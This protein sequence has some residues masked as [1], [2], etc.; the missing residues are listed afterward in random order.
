[1]IISYLGLKFTNL[2]NTLNQSWTKA[3]ALPP[4]RPVRD[5]NDFTNLAELSVFQFPIHEYHGYEDLILYLVNARDGDSEKVLELAGK[6]DSLCTLLRASR[7]SGLENKWAV[8]QMTSEQIYAL[9]EIAAG[10]TPRPNAYT[11][12]LAPYN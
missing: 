5:W 9:R 4:N 11:E 2:V 1:M 10:R 6:L 3:T 7:D 8:L 12:P